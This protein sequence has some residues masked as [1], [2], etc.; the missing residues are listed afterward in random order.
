MIY[1]LNGQANGWGE[2]EDCVFLAGFSSYASPVGGKTSS[3]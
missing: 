2:D 3:L 1:A